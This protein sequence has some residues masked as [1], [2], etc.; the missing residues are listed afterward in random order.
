[1]SAQKRNK[2]SEEKSD[3]LGQPDDK[4][5]VVQMNKAMWVQLKRLSFERNISMAALCR[6][7][8]SLIFEKTP[9]KMSDG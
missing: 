2:R 1:M 3:F 5:L 4:K 6:Q 9:L 7:G 8:I